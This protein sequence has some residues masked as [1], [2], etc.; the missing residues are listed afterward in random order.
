MIISEI[1]K[2]TRLNVQIYLKFNH[3]SDIDQ[4]VL[5]GVMPLVLG[6]V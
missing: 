6:N 2:K 3:Y 1:R 4:H 5:T